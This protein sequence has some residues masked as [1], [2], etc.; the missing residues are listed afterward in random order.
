[1]FRV[2]NDWLWNN[3]P[4][5]Q[6]YTSMIFVSEENILSPDGIQTIY[7]VHKAV[8]QLVTKNGDTWDEMC[9]RV[10]SLG[11]SVMVKIQ[12]KGLGGYLLLVV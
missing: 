9:I 3:F 11:D 5:E 6:R 8:Q 7:K 4:P 10:K 2:N 1:M 12:G